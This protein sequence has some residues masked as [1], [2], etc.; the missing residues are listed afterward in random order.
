MNEVKPNAFSSHFL[1]SEWTNVIDAWQLNT[2]EEY[3]N[4][5][6]LGRKNVWQRAKGKFYGRYSKRLEPHLKKT[7]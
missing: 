1:L 2:W 7:N 6:R 4:I 3:Q 5:K